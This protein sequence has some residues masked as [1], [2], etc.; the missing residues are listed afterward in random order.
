MIS[1]MNENREGLVHI[2]AEASAVI[3]KAQ[4]KQ[5]RNQLK[6]GGLSEFEIDRILGQELEETSVTDLDWNIAELL[7]KVLEEV[8]VL[9]YEL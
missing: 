5:Q 7:Q 1:H 6:K 8:E 4:E 9:I 3:A 2:S